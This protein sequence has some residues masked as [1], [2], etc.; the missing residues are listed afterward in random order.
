MKKFIVIENE[1]YTPVNIEIF[2][3]LKEA[4]AFVVSEASISFDIEF[5]TFKSVLKY[6][7]SD[8]WQCDETNISYHIIEKEV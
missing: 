2:N 8:K 3:N 6:Q 1:Y 4:R 5:K 7:E